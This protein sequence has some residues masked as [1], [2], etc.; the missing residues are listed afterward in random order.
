[1]LHADLAGAGFRSPLLTVLT[2]PAFLYS[3]R[4]LSALPSHSV[5]ALCCFAGVVLSSALL[6]FHYRQATKTVECRSAVARDGM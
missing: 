1:M 3:G 6:A 4:V 5:V 2:L